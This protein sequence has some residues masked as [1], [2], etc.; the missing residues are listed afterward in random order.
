M[1]RAKSLRIGVHHANAVVWE[2]VQHN[3]TRLIRDDVHAALV[4][5][6]RAGEYPSV[7]LERV[8]ALERKRIRAR[9]PRPR[10]RAPLERQRD[11][12]ARAVRKRGA[13]DVRVVVDA[14]AC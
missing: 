1:R 6:S 11:A 12:F 3:R 10:D 5:V 13:G 4:D 7:R 9:V 2:P 14:A 8:R